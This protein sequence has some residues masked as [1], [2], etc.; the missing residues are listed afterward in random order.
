MA[1]LRVVVPD[2]RRAALVSRNRSV[3]RVS[4][5]CPDLRSGLRPDEGFWVVVPSVE[6]AKDGSFERS[7]AIKGASTNRL[8]GDPPEPALDEVEPRR[9]GR[10]QMEMEARMVGKPLPN[11][12]M[13]VGSV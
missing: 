7:N 6:V 8:L 11:G 13:L 9:A 4:D 3:M 10:S 1:Y 12:R 5:A 2:G